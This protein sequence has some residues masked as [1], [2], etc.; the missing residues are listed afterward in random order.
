MTSRK[1]RNSR[2]D[3][4]LF[5]V[6]LFRASLSKGLLWGGG[7][8]LLFAFLFLRPFRIVPAGERGVIMHF[9]DVQDTILGEGMH[10][11][12]PIVTS[13]ETLSVRVQNS[14]ISAAASS[15][16]LQTLTAD[17][18]LN[19]HIDPSQ[20]NTIYQRVGDTE[21]IISG[22]ITPAVSEVVKAAT[23][24]KNAEQIIT[25]RTEL[26]ESIDTALRERLEPYGLLIDDVSLTNFSFSPEF[27]KSIEAKQVA[28]QE[29]KQ[30]EYTALKAEKDAQATI[31]R[32]KGQAEAQRLQDRTLSANILQQQAI[33]KWDGQYPDVMTQ[34]DAIPMLQI[35]TGEKEQP[36]Q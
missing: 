16:D 5:L 21:Q 17:I 24:K 20:V 14:E 10:F 13:V 3:F 29:A 27:S 19:W 22:I 11:T 28:E 6:D 33:E 7:F 25:Q 23:A 12:M 26:K 2:Q 4:T 34:G 8:F 35:L 1:P 15:K 31:N 36:A 32:A 9:G 30:A 18:A